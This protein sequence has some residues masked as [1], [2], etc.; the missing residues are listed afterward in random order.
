MTT[1]ALLFRPH[2]LDWVAAIRRPQTPADCGLRAQLQLRDNVPGAQYPDS[3]WI[4]MVGRTAD[5]D[6]EPAFQFAAA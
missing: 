6:N 5:V 3:A 4:T 2:R 1:P